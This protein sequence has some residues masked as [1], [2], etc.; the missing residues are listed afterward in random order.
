[1][2]E[3]GNKRGKRSLL[4]TLIS[5][6][7]PMASRH[8]FVIINTANI[9]KASTPTDY[10][11]NCLPLLLHRSS[12]QNER[13]H[14]LSCTDTRRPFCPPLQE[15]DTDCIRSGMRIRQCADVSFHLP[16][17]TRPSSTKSPWPAWPKCKPMS[18][19]LTQLH[20]S[21]LRAHYPSP[22]H[23]SPRPMRIHQH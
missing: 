3:Q 17:S 14:N 15:T 5:G 1:M 21:K 7:S 12:R 23:R 6:L 9:H 10:S 18:P 2:S 16:Q 22:N 4:P 20:P 11:T 8:Q 13:C 19:K